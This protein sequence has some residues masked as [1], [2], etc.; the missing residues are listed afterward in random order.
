MAATVE[1]GLALS[2]E[3]HPPSA[4]VRQAVRA[5]EA[6]FSFIGISDHFHPWVKAQ[7]HSPFVWGVLG[8]IAQA[9]E[10]IPVGTGVTCP[11]VRL[12]PAIVAQ[13]AATTA[14]L[15]P[16]RFFLGVGSGEALNEHI[17]GDRWP[18]APERLEMLEEA[19]EVIR[20]LW[21]GG[22]QDHHGKHYT[23]ENA[24]IFDLPDTLP[25]IVVAGGG[26]KAASLAGRAGDG[27][28]GTVPDREA[29]DAFESD[30]GAGKPRYGQITVC[31]AE[32]EEQARKTAFQVWPNAAIKGQLS[33]DLPT[34]K[35]FEEAAG[36][37]TEDDVA[38]TVVCGPDVSR[39]AAVV[40]KYADAGYTHLYVHQVGP[41]QDGFIRFWEQELRPALA[42]KGLAAAH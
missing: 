33:Q 8:A 36:M 30:G 19:V 11:T 31:W 17:L 42:E 23:V 18:T 9:T 12:H 34:P 14:C 22:S 7:G 24:T 39:H 5:E 20:T 13:A 21:Q 25:D 15:M 4:L 26:P 41:D 37:V 28:W 29:L 38:Q 27:Y 16:G 6:G 10:R 2:S 40:R 35:H 1:L 3:E 32:D